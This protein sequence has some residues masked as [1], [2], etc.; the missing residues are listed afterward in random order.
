MSEQ[1]RTRSVCKK[2]IH[3]SWTTRKSGVRYCLQCLQFNEAVRDYKR[4]GSL[5]SKRLAVI[6]TE[7]DFQVSLIESQ[8]DLLQA[9]ADSLRSEKDQWRKIVADKLE[10]KVNPSFDH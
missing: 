7:L 5:G 4:S 9:K 1:K 3:N 6:E 10:K 2:G 8:I